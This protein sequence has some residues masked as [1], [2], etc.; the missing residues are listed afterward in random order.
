MRPIS[1]RSYMRGMV[2]VS[3]RG[4]HPGEAGRRRRVKEIGKHH[5]AVSELERELKYTKEQLQT[6]VEEMETRRRN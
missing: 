4:G 5:K 6:T 3:F 1:G 2:L